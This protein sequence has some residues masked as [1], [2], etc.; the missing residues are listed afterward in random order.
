MR[1]VKHLSDTFSDHI[2]LKH[3]DISSLLHF[4]FA[5]GESKRISK[6]WKRLL[7]LL[8]S[9]N[10]LCSWSSLIMW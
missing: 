1:I 9:R 6:G 4:N 8:I 10:L 3:E 5:S 2:G 7:S